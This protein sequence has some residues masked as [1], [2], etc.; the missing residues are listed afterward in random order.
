MEPW[1][2]RDSQAPHSQLSRQQMVLFSSSHIRCRPATQEHNQEKPHQNFKGFFCTFIHSLRTPTALFMAKFQVYRRRVSVL[3]RTGPGVTFSDLDTV[4]ATAL[5]HWLRT[6]GFC[7]LP[8]EWYEESPQ[9][10]QGH[11]E[12][13]QTFGKLEK[14]NSSEPT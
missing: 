4:Y 7:F 8:V 9:N 5:P 14:S 3:F 6:C 13:I 12:T 11:S 10:R 1:Q 2:R